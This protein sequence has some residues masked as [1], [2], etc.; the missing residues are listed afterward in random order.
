MQIDD[1]KNHQLGHS[2]KSKV[3]EGLLEFARKRKLIKV[4]SKCS[5]LEKP[6]VLKLVSIYVFYIKS[7]ILRSFL[8]PYQM[9]VFITVFI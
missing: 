2:S 9:S 5:L 6:H 7:T 4:T 3:L 8:I 1:A